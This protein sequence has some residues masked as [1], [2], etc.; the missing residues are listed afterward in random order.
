MDREETCNTDRRKKL[1]IA[2]YVGLLLILISF[3]FLLLPILGIQF[4]A[5]GW[6]V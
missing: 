1:N 2:F 3:L 4:K 5:G 6:T